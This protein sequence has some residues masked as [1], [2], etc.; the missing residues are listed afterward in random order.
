[1]KFWLSFYTQFKL[2]KVYCRLSANRR[3]PIAVSVTPCC[4]SFS[5]LAAQHT[6][7]SDTNKQNIY[8]Y[9]RRCSEKKQWERELWKKLNRALSACCV[10]SNRLNDEGGAELETKLWWSTAMRWCEDIFSGCA[11]SRR[12]TTACGLTLWTCEPEGELRKSKS[13]KKGWWGSRGSETIRQVELW[14]YVESAYREVCEIIHKRAMLIDDISSARRARKN[15]LSLD[16]RR[17]KE[18]QAS[19][20]VCDVRNTGQIMRNLQLFCVFLV[21][22]DENSSESFGTKS[23]FLINM[24]ACINLEWVEFHSRSTGLWKREKEHEIFE[25]KLQ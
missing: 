6:M 5:F 16:M 17:V 12:D 18:R 2:I 1:M 4:R 24:H 14:S 11:E 15:I 8:T 20:R 22:A 25:N 19:D 21:A 10:R 9:M 3:P 13:R 7:R 23:I